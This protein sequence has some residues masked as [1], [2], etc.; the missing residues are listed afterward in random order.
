MALIDQYGINS[1]RTIREDGTIINMADIQGARLRSGS[2]IGR[3]T[4]SATATAIRIGS[5]DLTSRHTLS[6]IND[7]SD[8]FHIGLTSAVTTSD[9]FLLNTGAGI[10]FHF[11]PNDPVTV[12]AITSDNETNFEVLEL[13]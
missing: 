9:G 4:I 10:N 7:S 6:V 3:V 12:W 2:L 5:A 1:Y 8:L 11:D 13:K